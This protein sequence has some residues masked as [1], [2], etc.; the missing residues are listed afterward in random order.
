MRFGVLLQL[1]D[2]RERHEDRSVELARLN[3]QHARVVVGDDDPLDAVELYPVGFPEVRVLLE[4]DAVAAAP[5]F[6]REGA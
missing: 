6:E 4:H 3:L 1:R 2:P 5:L